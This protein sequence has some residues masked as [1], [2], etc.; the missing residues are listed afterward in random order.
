MFANHTVCEHCALPRE[1][2]RA[3]GRG[4]SAL[5]EPFVPLRSLSRDPPVQRGVQRRP[6]RGPRGAGVLVPRAADPAGNL[7]TQ[8]NRRHGALLFSL[9]R[10][11]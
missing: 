3:L 11:F 5:G 4:G 1:H 6:R 10:R 8:R 7:P 9:F 2:R